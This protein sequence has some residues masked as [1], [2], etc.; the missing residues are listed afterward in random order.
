MHKKIM[1]SDWSDWCWCFIQQQN[2]QSKL[3][4]W[5]NLH[6][7]N[8]WSSSINDDGFV[9]R[10]RDITRSIINLTVNLSQSSIHM[11]SE[12]DHQVFEQWRYMLNSAVVKLREAKLLTSPFLLLILQRPPVTSG[13]VKQLVF[14]LTQFSSPMHLRETR[15]SI[16]CS[17][18]YSKDSITCLCTTKHKSLCKL[19]VY[20]CIAHRACVLCPSKGP[21]TTTILSTLLELEKYTGI[22]NPNMVS[23]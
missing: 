22:I 11:C 6:L 12:S 21:C 16:S 14:L 5:P 23:D 17:N 1:V 20:M 18:M 8:I 10:F 7:F 19:L 3:L 2:K 15:N 13:T 9:L 4:Q